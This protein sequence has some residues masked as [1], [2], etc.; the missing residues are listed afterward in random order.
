[1]ERKMASI[2]RIDNIEPIEGADKIEVV[3][4]GGWKVVVN[5]GLYQP[6]DLVV[7]CEIDSWVPNSIAPFLTPEGKEPREYKGIKGERLRTKKLRGV[8][9]QGL[10][11]SLEKALE[12]YCGSDFDSGEELCEVFYDGAD[13][14][15]VMGIQK[16]EP[17]EE[18][19]SA[20]AK[21]TF[22]SFIRKTDQERIQ[23]IRKDIED[24]YQYGKFFEITEKLDGSSMTVFYLDGQV[25]VCSRNLELK[26]DCENTFWKTAMYS[27]AID[28]LI[29]NAKNLALQG[30]LIGPGI[31]GNSYGLREHEYHIYDVFDIDNQKYL[32]PYEA[33]L[34]VKGLGLKY[35][36]IVSEAQQ[37]TTSDISDILKYAE[38]KSNLNPKT[39]REGLVFKC[40]T[41][42]FSFKAISNK[43]LLK[44][45]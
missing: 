30:E 34:V 5:K 16:W 38:G 7:F 20:D 37:L 22:P 13:I 45:E 4:F 23:N 36:P 19:R 9:S 10:V 28:S 25:G 17:P 35:V 40:S 3:V 39:E 32:L 15:E 31:Q 1:M 6:N 29:T 8:I 11:L 33:N 24:S 18:F 2:R 21:G 26:E 43:W 42:D 12:A 14:S 27:G 44:N 41:E